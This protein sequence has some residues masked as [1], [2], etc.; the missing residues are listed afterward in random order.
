MERE[1]LS[2]FTTS[3]NNIQE[4]Y[5]ALSKPQK[6]LAVALKIGWRSVKLCQNRARVS[7]FSNKWQIAWPTCWHTEQVRTS[8]VRKTEQP[9]VHS[10]VCL[11]LVQLGGADQLSPVRINYEVKTNKLNANK[12]RFSQES[13]SDKVI[14]ILPNSTKEHLSNFRIIY[15]V[16]SQVKNKS[17]IESQ[18]KTNKSRF[19][20]ESYIKKSAWIIQQHH[21]P[22]FPCQKY[23]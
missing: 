10:L 17:L 5:R 3:Y 1:K 4:L 12:T 23:E 11:H 13:Y 19:K 15:T 18:V 7:C 20:T 9:D 6:Q 14:V 21:R 2:R 8:S 16:N 22:P